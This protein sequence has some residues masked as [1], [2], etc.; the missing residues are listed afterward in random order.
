VTGTDSTDS[1]QWEMSLLFHPSPLVLA[2]MPSLTGTDSLKGNIRFNSSEKM[3]KL[4]LHDDKIQINQ[5]LIHQFDAIAQTNG[6]GID[7]NISVADAGQKGFQLYQSSVYGTLA[8]N[9]L[10]TTIRLKDKKAKNRYVLA[11]NLSQVNKGIRFV[12][13][14]DSLLLNYQPW[15]IPKDNFV[16]YDS[17]GLI[18]RNLKLEHQGESITINSNENPRSHHSISALQNSE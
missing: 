15:Q 18:V 2:I 4:V 9:K 1:E 17:S 12:F 14:P 3:L 7:Y 11:G 6:K 16:H 13:S 10:S 5:Q 8:D